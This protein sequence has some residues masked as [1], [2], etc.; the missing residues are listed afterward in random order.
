MNIKFTTMAHKLAPYKIVVLY[1]A[2]TTAKIKYYKV[3]L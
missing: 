1:G 2:G 3:C